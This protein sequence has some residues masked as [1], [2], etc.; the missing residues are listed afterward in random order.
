MF[1]KIHVTG[2]LRGPINLAG[3]L[4]PSSPSFHPNRDQKVRP[5]T[6]VSKKSI[7]ANSWSLSPFQG[8]L[9]SQTNIKQTYHYDVDRIT[10]NILVHFIASD[11]YSCQFNLED[12]LTPIHHKYVIIHDMNFR[13]QV[14]ILGSK[15]GII[16]SIF[17]KNY[18]ASIPFGSQSWFWYFH[19]VP[20]ALS[21]SCRFRFFQ[22]HLRFCD[23]IWSPFKGWTQGWILPWM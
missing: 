23:A 20:M 5:S 3:N 16:P 8:W 12:S 11:L 1:L 21:F 14:G 13:K 10:F 6:P 7:Q 22:L 18:I 19:L 9:E 2:H 15:P 4:S 17:C